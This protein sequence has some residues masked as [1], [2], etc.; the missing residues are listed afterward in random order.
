[1]ELDGIDIR[2]VKELLAD[3]RISHVSLSRKVALS[4][5]ALLA[6]LHRLERAGI[7]RGFHAA[8]DRKLLGFP[9]TAFITLRYAQQISSRENVRL[10]S[11]AAHPQVIELHNVAGEDCFVLKVSAQSVDDLSKLLEYLKDTR[12][13]VTSKTTLVLSTLFEKPYPRSDGIG[14]AKVSPR[15]AR[16]S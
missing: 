5:P 9:I 1:M 14:Q 4:R 3:A 13:P 15:E 7:F 11:L 8:V 16:R 10:R 2:I 6:R 12:A